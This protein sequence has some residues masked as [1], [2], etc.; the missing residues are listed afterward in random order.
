MRIKANSKYLTQEIWNLT[1]NPTIKSKE[2]D[3]I[4]I[5]V[6]DFEKS[7]SEESKKLIIPRPTEIKMKFDDLM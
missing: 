3:I 1:S 4:S 5:I 6:A 7:V 2:R